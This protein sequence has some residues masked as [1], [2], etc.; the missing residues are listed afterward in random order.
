MST[1]ILLR[2]LSREYRHWGAF[3]AELQREMPGTNVIP[4]DLPGNG[5]LNEMRSPI[6]I[7]GMV[8]HC[9]RELA[10]QN[11]SPPYALLAISMGAMVAA[12]W[13]HECPT[14]VSACVLIN[15]SFGSFNS[16]HQRLRPRAWTTL[17]KILIAASGQR[18]EELIYRMTSRRQPLP[19][20]LLD[21]WVV[22]RRSR[23]VSAGNALR[24]LVAAARFRAPPSAPVS[25]LILASARD[26]LVDVRCSQEIA[27][28]WLCPMVLHPDA[29]HDLPL[30]DGAWVA[31]QVREWLA[32]KITKL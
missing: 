20:G 15:S 8:A 24:Q 29:G 27:R 13:A 4:I 11:V 14:E 31:R 7:H 3:P 26:E 30:D 21:E 18:R 2:G 28:R 23:P 19:P 22:I 12:K 25:T 9:R 10:R 5:S 1:W 17:L 16:F 32:E 6:D